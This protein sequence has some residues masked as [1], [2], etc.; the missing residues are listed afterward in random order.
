MNPQPGRV[1]PCDPAR[2]HERV[3]RMPGLAAQ[4]DGLLERPVRMRSA[5]QGAGEAGGTECLEQG[6]IEGRD[7]EPLMDA[8]ATHHAQEATTECGPVWRPFQFE[9]DLHAS[10]HQPKRLR[11]QEDALT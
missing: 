10:R 1:G 7:E 4:P 2:A 3:A 6:G 5:D 8:G 9:I 11:N